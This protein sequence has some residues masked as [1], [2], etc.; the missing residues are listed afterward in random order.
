MPVAEMPGDL[1]QVGGVPGADLDQVLRF[2]ANLDDAPVLEFQPVAVAQVN[3]GRFV[4]KHGQPGFAGQDRPPAVAVFPVEGNA[5]GGLA[6]PGAGGM[7]GGNPDHAASA[8]LA[9]IVWKAGRP[10][11]RL[12]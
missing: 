9:I 11:R 12:K 2:G 5:V 4:E 1:D 8:T 6:L 10:R 3:R 7:N